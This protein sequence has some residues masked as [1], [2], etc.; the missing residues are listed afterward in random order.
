MHKISFLEKKFKDLEFLEPGTQSWLEA[1]QWCFGGSEIHAVLNSTPKKFNNILT[2]KT[3]LKNVKKDITNWGHLFEPVAKEY[4][5]KFTTTWTKL[6]EFGT[7]SHPKYPIAYSPDGIIV[8]TNEKIQMLEIKCPIYKNLDKPIDE[9]Y[10]YQIQSGMNVFPVD[11]GIF[12]RCRFRRC[13]LWMKPE[14]TEYDSFYHKEFKDRKTKI[15]PLM[16]GYLYWKTENEIFDL[17][18]ENNMLDKMPHFKPEIIM[19]KKFTPN[20]GYVLMWKLFEIKIEPIECDPLFLPK[21]ETVLWSKYKQLEN[22]HLG[23]E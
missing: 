7:L 23:I 12:I 4:L 16:Y 19:N 18:T 3:E 2:T 10:L 22:H 6:Y 14:D 17:A 15:K 11:G 20:K 5:D 8:D 9:S 1:R 21:H 13:F